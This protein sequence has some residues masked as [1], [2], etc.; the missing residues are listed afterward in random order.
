MDITARIERSKSSEKID[1]SRIG[2]LHHPDRLVRVEP[3]GLIMIEPIWEVA[4]D[5]EGSLY[6]AYR[7]EHPEYDSI[8]MRSSVLQRLE[9]AAKSFQGAYKIVLHA[10]HRP[11][12][13][14]KQLLHDMMQDYKTNHPAA[15]DAEVLTHARMYVSDP[16]IKL[17]PHCCGDAVDIELYDTTANQYIDFGSPV[18]EDSDI[19]HLHSPEVTAAQAANRQLLLKAMLD[20]GFAS[21]YAEWWHFSYGDEIWAWFYGKDACLFGLI[22]K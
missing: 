10:G 13:V 11:L 21:Y 14:Q 16:A 22:E 20:A 6:A 3:S 8:Y 18:N 1:F 2:C 15:S 19:S 7:K 12:G 17:P 9:D 4:G 5:Y